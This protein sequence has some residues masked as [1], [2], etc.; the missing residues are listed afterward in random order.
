MV[1]GAERQ[2]SR[3][4]MLVIDMQVGVMTGCADEHV[5][6]PART[7]SSAGLETQDAVRL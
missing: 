3:T 4:V 6:S 5:S 7:R 1:T 2:R